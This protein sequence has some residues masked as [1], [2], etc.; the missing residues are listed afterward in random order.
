MARTA[1][2]AVWLVSGC[3][4]GREVAAVDAAAAD[5][6]AADAGADRVD[7][8]GQPTSD[9]APDGALEPECAVSGAPGVC[10]AT[11]ACAALGG[12][13]SIPGHCPGPADIQCCIET[14]SPALNPP[15][16]DGYQLMQQSDVTAAM[17]AWA[18]EIL[19]DPVTYP[20]FATATR[21]FDTLSV[22][23]RVEWHA[24]DFQNSA[25]HRGVTLY[26]PR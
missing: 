24:P 8:A 25:V 10:I 23:A 12:H 16:P 22:L 1:M 14:P 19:N 4:I 20:M 2:L 7:D 6:A 18:I 9:A 17:T 15:V 3:A 21:T 13:S 5:A 26:R 11:A